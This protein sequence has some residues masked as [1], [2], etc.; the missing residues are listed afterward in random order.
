MVTMKKTNPIEAMKIIVRI[1]VSKAMIM[2]M[3][4]TMMK[5]KEKTEKKVL[6]SLMMRAKEMSDRDEG[7]AQ[8]GRTTY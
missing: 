5:L 8:K 7:V 3:T 4:K 1:R 2:K 6:R